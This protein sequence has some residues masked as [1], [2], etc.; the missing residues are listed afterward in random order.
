M[1]EIF[2][3]ISTLAT[4][5]S[6]VFLVYGMM[7]SEDDLA[8]ASFLSLFLLAGAGG[9]GALCGVIPV[10][11]RIIS[12]SSNEVEVVKNSY[13][14]YVTV[15]D[16]DYT[17]TSAKDYSLINDSTHFYYKESINSYGGVSN[18]TLYYSSEPLESKSEVQVK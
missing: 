18:R 16:L 9:W 10:D 8:F 11:S 13:K 6:L 7:N 12:V 17:Y 15:G 14:V 4:F 5:V 1:G 2:I 3:G